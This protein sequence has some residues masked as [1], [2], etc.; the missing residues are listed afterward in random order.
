MA[1]WLTR[2]IPPEQ[3]LFVSS[4][5][6]I[7]DIDD[8]GA[9]DGPKLRVEANRGASGIDGVVS[10]AAGFA[11]GC[12]RPCTALV[13]DIA[14]LHDLNALGMLANVET[15]L[16]L[17]V[18]NNGGGSI[19]SFLPVADYSDVFTPFFDTPHTLR[20]DGISRSFGLSYAHATS[21]GGFERAYQQAVVSDEHALIEVAS[22]QATNLASHRAIEKALE[23]AVRSFDVR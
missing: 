20:F 23:A 9:L 21:R 12:A 5:M 15:P 11:R 10:A 16:T 7:R 6:P 2:H 1:R 3:V 4:S 19:F 8:Y 13:G 18:L 14:L 22:D 17:V